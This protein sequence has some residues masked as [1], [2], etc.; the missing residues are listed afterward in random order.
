MRRLLPPV[1]AALLLA[2]CVGPKPE[3]RSATVAP[4]QEGKATVT[5]VVVN[6]G[7]G[8]GQIEVRITLRDATGGV[9][10]RDEKTTVLKERET[11]TVVL[12]VQVPE[13]AEGLKV[14]AEV[15]YPPD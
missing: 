14:D 1:L 4:P 5:V 6:R 15:T 3:V 12:E 8:D 2:A 9:V 13:D 10:S 7:G 11:I